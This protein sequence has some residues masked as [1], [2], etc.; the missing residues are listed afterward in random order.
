M[1]ACG[2]GGCVGPDGAWLPVGARWE[3]GDGCSACWCAPGGDIECEADACACDPGSEWWRSYVATDPMMCQLIDY[4]CP[5]STTG[6]SNACG[7]GCQQSASCPQ[8][9]D[10]MP[11][12]GCDPAAVQQKCPYTKIAF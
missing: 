1:G 4:A 8:Y 12:K 3:T 9:I 2:G 6:F 10:C 11:P 5:E 7:C